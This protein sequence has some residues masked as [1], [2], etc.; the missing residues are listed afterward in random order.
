MCNVVEEGPPAQGSTRGYKG[1]SQAVGGED[2]HRVGH[3]VGV[4]GAWYMCPEG[5]G[6]LPY[7]KYLTRS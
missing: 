4:R 7:W 6:N 3:R 5:V 1:H 2:R